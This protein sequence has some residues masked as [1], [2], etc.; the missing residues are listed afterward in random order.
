MARSISA[1]GVAISKQLY[2]VWALKVRRGEA[3]STQASLR[4][5]TR[6]RCD[7]DA[8]QDTED[9]HGKDALQTRHTLDLI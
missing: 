4:G 7:G 8:E 6:V 5:E 9:G 2:L 1:R 3:V